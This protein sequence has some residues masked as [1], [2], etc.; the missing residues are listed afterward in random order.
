MDGELTA[1][2]PGLD[3]VVG[4][5]VVAALDAAHDQAR[6]VAVQLLLHLRALG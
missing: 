1:V 4:V 6:Q 3:A 5:A 2:A